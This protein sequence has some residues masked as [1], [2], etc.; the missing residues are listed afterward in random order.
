[1]KSKLMIVGLA[2]VMASLA[3]WA[4]GLVKGQPALQ[5]AA[6][7]TPATPVS[8]Y[9]PVRPPQPAA[10]PPG[11]AVP[12]EMPVGSPYVQQGQPTQLPQM[13]QMPATPGAVQMMQEQPPQAQVVD[14]PTGRQEPAVSIEWI[15]PPTAKVG[16]AVTYQIIVKNIS[17]SA[18]QDVVVKQ[19]VPAGAR[20]TATEPKATEEDHVLTWALG[21]LEPRQ[22]KRLDLQVL[23]EAAGSVVCNATVTITGSASTRLQVYEPKLMI[24]AT[25]PDKVV[26]GDP[27][28]VQLTVTNP[29]DASCEQVKITAHLSDGLEHARGQSIEYDLGSLRPKESRTVQVLCGAKAEGEQKCMVTVTADPVLSAQA[30]ATIQVLMPRVELAIQGPG[31]RY[32]DRHAVYQF[33]V[34]NPGTAIANHVTLVDQVPQG[35]KFI[36]ASAEGRH[37]FVSR[38]VY[39]SLGDIPPGETKEVSLELIAVNPGEHRNKAVA[40]AARGLKAEGETVTRV[41]G[42]PAL[43]ME[44]VD[45]DDPVEVGTETSYEVRVTNTG[46]KTETNL[47]LICTVPEKMEFR[48]AKGAAGLG[49]KVEG[50]EVIFE[51]LLKLAPRA[52]AIY[53]INVKGSA[54]GDLR[55]RAKIKADGLEE[56][57]LKEESTKVYGDEVR[58]ADFKQ[59]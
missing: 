10:L 56:A 26:L 33:K 2:L 9:H 46:T 38:T 12:A 48:G 55:F 41:E 39:W 13:M 23:P 34:T 15:G 30:E 54:P 37:D 4:V 7:P 58:Q 32:L 42:L 20:V 40:A 16:Q 35:F 14:N 59:P 53:R 27:A 25:G 45:L 29:G 19:S 31:L 3:V 49:F 21:T 52:D 17:A 5:P 1:M 51:P 57:V 24:K 28:P 44:L 8:T 43:L 11:V 47:V 6:E 36:S 22:E 18:A 50:K